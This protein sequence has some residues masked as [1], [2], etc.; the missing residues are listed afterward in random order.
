MEF[1]WFVMVEKSGVNEQAESVIASRFKID[2][3]SPFQG[4]A[5]VAI[6]CRRSTT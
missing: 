2:H 1:G 3:W 5:P 6:E 4:F